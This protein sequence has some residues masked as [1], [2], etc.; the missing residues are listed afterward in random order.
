MSEATP[1]RK[2]EDLVDPQVVEV[3]TDLLEKAKRGEIISFI[4]AGATLAGG[5]VEARAG[6]PHPSRLIGAIECLKFWIMRDQ[7]EFGEPESK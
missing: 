2:V 3:L 4:F 1:L 7:V 5:T 6:Y